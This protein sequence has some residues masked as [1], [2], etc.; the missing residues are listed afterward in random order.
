[1]RAIDCNKCADYYIRRIDRLIFI[2]GA[3]FLTLAATLFV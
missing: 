2:S 3:M 1:M